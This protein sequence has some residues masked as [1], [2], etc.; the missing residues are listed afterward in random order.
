M[1]NLILAKII[2][3]FQ[4]LVVAVS[5]IATPTPQPIGVIT[6]ISPTPVMEVSPTPTPEITPITTSTPISTPTST[7]MPEITPTPIFTP[8]PTPIPMPTPTPTPNLQETIDTINQQIE[9]LKNLPEPTPT[10]YPTDWSPVTLTW[11]EFGPGNYQMF[12]TNT[13]ITVNSITIELLPDEPID[14]TDRPPMVNIVQGNK[15][16]LGVTTIGT[17]T[18]NKQTFSGNWSFC[19][20]CSPGGKNQLY[21]SWNKQVKYRIVDIKLSDAYYI[22]TPIELSNY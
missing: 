22:N 3:L 5:L 8:A 17:F 12:S 9:E 2:S 4:S 14:F 1:F 20:N 7:P 6:P 21:V 13:D 10:P 11:G 19:N 16:R 15:T 18:K